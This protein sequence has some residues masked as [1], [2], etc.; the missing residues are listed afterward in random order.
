MKQTPKT[1]LKTLKLKHAQNLLL[2]TEK[3]IGEI[4]EEVGY[5]SIYYFCNDFKKF[6]GRTPL[7]FRKQP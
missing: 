7:Q 6:T 5:N 1:Y 2:N 3:T 4:A